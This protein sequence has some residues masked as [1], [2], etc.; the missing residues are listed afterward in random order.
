MVVEGNPVAPKAD[1]ASRLAIPLE[2][3]LANLGFLHW[4]RLLSGGQR[5]Y[6]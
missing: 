6:L 1:V 5:N 3:T 4:K 2:G